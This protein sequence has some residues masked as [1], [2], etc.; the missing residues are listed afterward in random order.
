MRV[1]QVDCVAWVGVDFHQGVGVGPWADAVPLHAAASV[2]N[3]DLV[4]FVCLKADGPGIVARRDVKR[5][6]VPLVLEGWHVCG[7]KAVDGGNHL[8]AASV[9]FTVVAA[10]Q[11]HLTEFHLKTWHHL[12][13]NLRIADDN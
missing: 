10:S 5:T 8:R 6:D 9:L 7:R 1:L 12:N 13:R 11:L 2:G 4:E 3:L